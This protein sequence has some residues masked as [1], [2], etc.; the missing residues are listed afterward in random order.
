MI[1]VGFAPGL[2]GVFNRPGSA[3]EHH[4]S[5]RRPDRSVDALLSSLSGL[6]LKFRVCENNARIDH[7]IPLGGK[8]V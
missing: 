7:N 4:C 6:A 5:S 1:H 3:D 2:T 8:A